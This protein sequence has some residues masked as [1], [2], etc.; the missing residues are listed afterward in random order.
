[1]GEPKVFERGFI[2]GR[3]PPGYVAFPETTALEIIRGFNAR[4]VRYAPVVKPDRSLEGMVSYRELFRLILESEDV[5]SKLRSVRAGSLL[6]RDTP[7]VVAYQTTASELLKML[8]RGG[9]VL[10]V[11]DEEGRVIG[12]ISER[13]AVDLLSLAGI[14][15]ITVNELMTKEPVTIEAGSTLRE[16][17]ALMVEKGVRRLPVVYDDELV[18]IVQVEDVLHHLVLYEEQLLLGRAE[19]VLSERLWKVV[20]PLLVTV[21]LG[22]HLADALIRMR[23]D[24]VSYVLVVDDEELKGIMTERDVVTK[25][26]EIVGEERMIKLMTRHGGV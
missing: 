4:S 8:R 18:G 12:Q 10:P 21:P 13:H 3:Y 2:I 11:V 9:G 26:P 20:P 16:A 25:L 1:M 14:T 5:S 6:S 23:N 17:I 24:G 7:K 15:D 22:T 19:R